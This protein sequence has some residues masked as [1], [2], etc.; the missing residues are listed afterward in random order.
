MKLFVKAISDIG[1]VRERNE[2][3]IMVCNELLRDNSK[4]FEFQLEELKYPLLIA[5][6][7]GMGGNKGGQIASEIVLTEMKI[8][9]EEISSEITTH[10]FKSKLKNQINLIHKK[11]LDEGKISS[12]RMGM[13]S[14][15]TGVIFF[16]KVIY[17]LNVGDSRIY[18]F[19]NG[20]L[21]QLSRDHSLREMMQDPDAPQN[22]IV[23]S[24]GAGE[25]IFFDLEDIST[26]ILSEDYLL[27]CSDG[28]NSELSDEE[29]EMYLT[30]EL[31][32]F[33][34]VSRVKEKG[35]NDNISVALISFE[36]IIYF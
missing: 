19:R 15:F 33:Q 5:I 20:I 17:L 6:A 24:F 26:R 7:D 12:E 31:N 16:E 22:I 35:G 32:I 34:L 36:K 11:I 10:E 28:L 1:N 27:L 3:M 25:N 2:D 30:Q 4:T 21:T 14:T 18:R 29:I 9:F 23:N 13:G 8:F